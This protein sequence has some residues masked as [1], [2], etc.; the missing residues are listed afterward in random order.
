MALGFQNSYVK[1]LSGAFAKKPVAV[2][3]AVAVPPESQLRLCAIL[4]LVKGSSL[5]GNV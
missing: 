3:D 2:V 4:A 1:L 5:L